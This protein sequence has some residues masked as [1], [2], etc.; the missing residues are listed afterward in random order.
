M[1]GICMLGYLGDP[2]Q[3]STP[4]ISLARPQHWCLQVGADK[5]LLVFLGRVSNCTL[6]LLH[7]R[8]PRPRD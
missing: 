1:S 4:G 8:A 5:K 7:A 6:S 3:A 2:L